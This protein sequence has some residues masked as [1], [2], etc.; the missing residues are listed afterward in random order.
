LITVTGWTWD[1]I[2]EHMDFPRLEAMN[3]YWQKSPPVHL[4]M[5]AYVGWGGEKADAGDPVSLMETLPVMEF[6]PHGIRRAE[7]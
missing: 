4:S 2:D 7:D 6:N 3:R 1:Y 5:A